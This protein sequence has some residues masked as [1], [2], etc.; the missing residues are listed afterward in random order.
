MDCGCNQGNQATWGSRSTGLVK[1]AVDLR[2]TGACVEA[3]SGTLAGFQ[4]DLDLFSG[5]VTDV[6]RARTLTGQEMRAQ[7]KRFLTQTNGLAARFENFSGETALF[8]SSVEGCGQNLKQ[9][10]DLIR[11]GSAESGPEMIRK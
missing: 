9:A 6:A 2:R 3:A 8:K 4:K 1:L 7:F 5:A 10:G 11:K